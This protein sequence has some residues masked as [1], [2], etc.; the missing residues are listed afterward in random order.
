MSR[1]NRGIVMVV[2]KD[3]GTQEVLEPAD[4]E[5]KHGWK[6]DPSKVHL[7][8]PLLRRRCSEPGQ[9][10]GPLALVL[11]PAELPDEEQLDHR[12]GQFAGTGQG[13]GL[14]SRWQTAGD[15]RR[16]RH[17]PPLGHAGRQTDPYVDRRSRVVAVVVEGRPGA[18]HQGG[19]KEGE[20]RQWNADTGR[21]LRRIT[22]VA[23]ARSKPPVPRTANRRPRLTTKAFVCT[24]PPPAS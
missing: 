23:N 15:G 24:T 13:S 8:R 3:D 1:S 11:Q 22:G 12:D 4:F 6:N 17:H 10:M 7:L 5:Q 14:S 9:P 18:D 21:L 20:A 2:Q 16:R 19:P